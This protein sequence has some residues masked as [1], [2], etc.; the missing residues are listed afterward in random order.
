MKDERV[1]EGAAMDLPREF[2]AC[3]A[4]LL[5]TIGPDI[6]DKGKDT[7]AECLD[8]HQAFKTASCGI[9]VSYEILW[10]TAE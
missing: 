4:S 7:D 10:D 2:V 5:S 6:V 8:S 1:I 3:P 9:T